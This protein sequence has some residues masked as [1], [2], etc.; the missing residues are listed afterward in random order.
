MI[1]KLLQS[2]KLIAGILN[3]IEKKGEENT[4]DLLRDTLNVDEYLD[5]LPNCTDADLL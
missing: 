2:I 3:P 1:Q 4:L 5:T